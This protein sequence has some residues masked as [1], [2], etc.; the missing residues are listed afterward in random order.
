MEDDA[1]KEGI[2]DTPDS[3]FAFLIERVRTNLHIVLCMS[4][5]GDP[6]RCVGEGGWE[7]HPQVFATIA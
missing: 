5:V 2:D 3:M 6:F 1:K 7:V 4:P